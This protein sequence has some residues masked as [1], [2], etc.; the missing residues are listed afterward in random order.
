MNIIIGEVVAVGLG[1]LF[2][3]PFAALC[4]WIAFKIGLFK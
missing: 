1:L 2:G 4:V 3:I